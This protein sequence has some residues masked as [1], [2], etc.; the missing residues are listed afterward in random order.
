MNNCDLC[1]DKMNIDDRYMLACDYL[2]PTPQK[3][4]HACYVKYNGLF[5]TKDLEELRKKK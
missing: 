2:H 4:C 5:T 3:V 1:G